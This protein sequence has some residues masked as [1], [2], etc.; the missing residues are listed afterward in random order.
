MNIEILATGDELLTGALSD[1]N[2]A[3][4][5][6]GLSQNH[7]KVNRHHVVGDDLQMISSI[8]SEIA[9]R[10]NVLIVTGGLGP[11]HDDLSAEAAAKASGK[12]LVYNSDAYN[13]LCQ[14]FERIQRP[15]NESNKKQAYL[16]EGAQ[17]I[18]NPV[19]TASGFMAQIGKCRS[20]FL[21]GVP[22]EMKK[23]FNDHVLPDII[24]QTNLEDQKTGAQTIVCFG[25]SESAIGDAIKDISQKISGIRV[26]TR[27]KFPEIQIKLYATG[28][29]QDHINML[30]KKAEQLCIDR[31]GKYI[32]SLNGKSMQKVVGNLLK[33]RG[34][35]LSIAESCTGGLIAHLLTQVPG[36][37]DYF[38]C[39]AV[40]YA[41]D[42]KINILDVSPQTIQKYGAVSQETVQEMAVEIRQKMGSHYALATSGIAGPGGGTSEKPVGTLC[43]AVAYESG[44][45]F[46]KVVLP[47]GTRTQK[48]ELFAMVA[49]DMLRRTLLNIPY[50]F[51]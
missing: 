48:K 12:K 23:M 36:S 46:Q 28:N 51:E 33:Q 6:D 25:L 38:L 16:P 32:V 26:G 24:Q 31:L 50:I 18:P 35:T 19:G 1:T 9:Q 2:S 22:H 8:L 39:S 5:A 40:T 21:P 29:S 30:L 3:F 10:T 4:I 41:N 14:F 7:L 27:S 20:Y 37:S 11:T 34:A 15:M 45:H 42:A 13:A 49:M 47:F 44:V 17:R 43:M